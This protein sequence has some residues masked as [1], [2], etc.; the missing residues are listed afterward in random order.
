MDAGAVGETLVRPGLSMNEWRCEIRQPNDSPDSRCIGRAK[1]Q[2]LELTTTQ[3]PRNSLS[4]A[5]MA[6]SFLNSL[7]P[8]YADVASFSS[9]A[10]TIVGNVCLSSEISN[11]LT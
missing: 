8:G 2:S 3:A 1:R 5:Y 9:S 4:P 7:R 6:P 10:R 11:R